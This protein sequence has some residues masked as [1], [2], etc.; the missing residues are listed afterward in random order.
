LPRTCVPA[1]SRYL[2]DAVKADECS[3]IFDGMGDN[4]VELPQI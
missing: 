1:L 3:W 2:A 4:H